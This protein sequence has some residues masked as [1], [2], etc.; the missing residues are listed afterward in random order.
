MMLSKHLNKLAL[1]CIFSITSAQA[2]PVVIDIVSIYKN[3]KLV[4][5]ANTKLDSAEAKFKRIVG[6]AELEM[7]SLKETGKTKELQTKQQEI[8]KI[9]D[10]EMSSLQALRLQYNT[11]I[12]NNIATALEKLSKAKSYELILDKAFVVSDIHDATNELITELEK[13]K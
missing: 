6:T 2:K 13:L 4:L 7:Q 3:Y 10:T 12:N 9:I 8:Q 5:E 11:R 1:L